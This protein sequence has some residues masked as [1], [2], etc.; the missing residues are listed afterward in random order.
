MSDP[1]PANPSTPAGA[2][3]TAIRPAPQK[4]PVDQLPPFKV[5]LHNDDVNTQEHVIDTLV[6]LT[7]LGRQRAVEIVLEVES[8][9]VGLI[10]VTHKEAAE[11]FHDQLKSKSLTVTIEPA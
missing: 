9:G 10:L 3:V 11:H 6:E 5:L 1:A 4:P 2:S 7:T 8:T